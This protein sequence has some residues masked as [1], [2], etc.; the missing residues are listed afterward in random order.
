[1]NDDFPWESGPEPRTWKRHRPGASRHEWNRNTIFLRPDRT[2][3]PQCW[4]CGYRD[5]ASAMLEDR[6]VLACFSCWLE[7]NKP[8]VAK[9]YWAER[10]GQAMDPLKGK[11]ITDSGLKRFGKDETA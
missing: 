1:M 3:E 6:G 8:D 5:Y 11:R 9:S 10:D 4:I 2:W 7:E